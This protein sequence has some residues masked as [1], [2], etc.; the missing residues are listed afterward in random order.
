MGYDFDTDRNYN[1]ENSVSMII[2]LGK[3]C[4]SPG[5]I[6]NGGIILKPK[7]S[8]LL[9]YLETPIATLYLT[10]H[11]YYTYSESEYN[12]RTGRNE[13]VSKVAEEYYP[14]LNNPLN[15]SNFINADM[16]NT[17]KLPFSIQ[18]PLRIYPSCYFS[19]S[20]YVKHYL[21]IDFPSIGAKKS[22]I[23]VIKNPQY[24]STYNHLYQSPAVCYKETTKHSMIFFSKGSF[25][26]SLKLE[27][28][29]FAYDE[30]IH[31][32]VK[33]DLTKMSLNIKNIV[34][35]IKRYYRKNQRYNHEVA[36]NKSSS[37]IAKKVCAVPQN[38]KIIQFD[39]FLSLD[40]DKNP[41]NVYLKLDNDHRKT[42]Q[43]FSGISLFPTCV[44]GLLSVEHILK[45]EL[46]MDTFWSTNEEVQIPIDLYE[47]FII[48]PNYN[49][50]NNTQNMKPYS[51]NPNMIGTPETYPP[52]EGFTYPPQMSQ[53]VPQEQQIPPPN[54]NNQDNQE[55]LPSIE[56][57][58]KKPTE[59]DES[60]APPTA[61]MINN[62][63]NSNDNN[64][65]YPDFK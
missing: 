60:P 41:K 37:I 10:E 2:E 35:T 15:F 54:N 21:T 51:Q 53:V 56:E 38:Q 12:P 49:D 55:N 22:V 6:L 52:Q 18:I 26:A 50:F 32:D 44:G 42:S 57:I 62:N 4:F 34:L 47:P 14:I 43:K 65:N 64:N 36:Y 58:M 33:L 1:F 23:I 63:N 13:Y 27:K 45:M 31:F 46:V 19:S 30:N 25:S 17:L 3:T 9:K 8:S 20:T 48:P 59:D 11:A 29:A 7:E 5:E 61:S 40:P 16:S 24:F 39:G 28:N